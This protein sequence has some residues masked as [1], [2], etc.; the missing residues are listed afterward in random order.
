MDGNVTCGTPSAG[1][2]LPDVWAVHEPDGQDTPEHIH[3]TV[4]T[5]SL[6]A[7]SYFLSANGVAVGDFT[8]NDVALD[9]SF[10]D[11]FADND[12]AT[13]NNV[14]DVDGFSVSAVV[15]L[16]APGDVDLVCESNQPHTHVEDVNAIALAV[17]T[18][19][20]AG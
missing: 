4:A 5:L 10:G 9:C 11:T 1:G 3:T 13:S 7:G 19:H 16:A 14:A 2:S 12:G 18:V 8:G 6:P 17:G 20:Q 15:T